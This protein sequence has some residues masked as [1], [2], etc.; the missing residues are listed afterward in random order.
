M[1]YNVDTFVNVHSYKIGQQVSD[2]SQSEF[3]K[4]VVHDNINEDAFPVFVYELRGEPVAWY[5]EENE[6]GIVV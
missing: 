5:D 1:S 4:L 6:F 2:V 3:E